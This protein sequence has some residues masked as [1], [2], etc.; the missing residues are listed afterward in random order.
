[1]FEISTIL[2]YRSLVEIYHRR[3]LEIFILMLLNCKQYQIGKQNF[4]LVNLTSQMSSAGRP[5][6]KEDNNEVKI[7]V[8][9]YPSQSSCELSLLFGVS[10][11]KILTYLAQSE[12]A[13]T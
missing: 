13:S 8:E 9:S 2:K 11:I 10:D 3:Q 12:N 1:M 5:E 7:F 6:T 4:V